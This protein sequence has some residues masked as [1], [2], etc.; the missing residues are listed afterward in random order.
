MESRRLVQLHVTLA[1][2]AEPRSEPRR[3]RRLMASSQLGQIVLQHRAHS[4]S[5]E[6]TS[7]KVIGFW[8]KKQR[9]R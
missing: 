4:F 5:A 1:Y 6:V 3:S 7:E 2:K 8:L 9:R